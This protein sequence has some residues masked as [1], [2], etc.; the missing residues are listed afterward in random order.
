MDSIWCERTEAIYDLKGDSRLPIRDVG[1]RN[2]YV[3]KVTQFVKN[4]INAENVEED[5][6]MIKETN[7]GTK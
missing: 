3:G 5:N 2:I 7:N 6:L 1:V 4:V